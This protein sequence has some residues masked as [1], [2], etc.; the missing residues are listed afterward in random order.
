MSSSEKILLIPK[1]EPN[2]YWKKAKLYA[3]FS[4]GITIFI[5]L[6]CIIFFVFTFLHDISE[7]IRKIVVWINVGYLGA[8]ISWSLW[9]LFKYYSA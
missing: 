5:S 8:A 2:K 1:D 4:I 7:N 3:L 6:L 9:N